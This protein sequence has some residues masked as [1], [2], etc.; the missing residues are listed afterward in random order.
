MKRLLL[1]VVVLSFLV[2]C[3]NKESKPVE[4]EI[5]ENPV[6]VYDH[7]IFFGDEF[8]LE[9]YLSYSEDFEGPLPAVILVHGSGANDRNSAVGGTRIFEDIAHA[10]AAEGIATLRYDKRTFSYSREIVMSDKFSS[11]TV[12]EETIDDVLLAKA[13]LLEHPMI[14]STRIFILGHSMGGMLAPEIHSQSSFA[15]IIMLAGTPRSM[16]DVLVSQSEDVLLTVENEFEKKQILQGME[17]IESI[18][19]MT[20]EES[21]NL[22]LSSIYGYYLL[23][24]ERYDT[25]TI[26]ENLEV[27]ILIMQGTDDFQVKVERDYHL[28]VD[29][30]SNK[31]NINFKLYEGLNH[32]FMVS[33]GEHQYTVQEY[34]AENYVDETVLEDIIEFI[35]AYEAK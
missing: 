5:V 17:L 9:G 18:K 8:P 11:F 7:E 28:Y 35:K 34:D 15:G 27:P 33:G 1:I 32:L 16:I 10:L 14:D 20:E 13:F 2:S 3:Q 4:E 19:Y 6:H 12:Q 25:L 21:K 23:D 22:N 26:L 24:F 30:L 31:E 29:A